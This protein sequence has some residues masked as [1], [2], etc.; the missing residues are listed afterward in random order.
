MTGYSASGATGI[1]RSRH[2]II[3]GVCRGIADHFDLSVFWFRMATLIG[4]LVSGFAPVGFIYILAA[5]LM[6]VE[7]DY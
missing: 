6:K 1:Y 7:P 2:G 5:L 4:F 3:F